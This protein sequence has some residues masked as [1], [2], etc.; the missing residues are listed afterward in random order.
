MIVLNINANS[1]PNNSTVPFGIIIE[2]NIPTSTRYVPVVSRLRLFACIP[3]PMKPNRTP[4][5]KLAKMFV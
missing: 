4:Q 1:N 3:A 2:K 5:K